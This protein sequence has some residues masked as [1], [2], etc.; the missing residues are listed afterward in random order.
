MAGANLYMRAEPSGGGRPKMIITEA[1]KQLIEN[2]AQL[3]CTDEEIAACLGTTNETLHN[4]NNKLTFLECKQKGMEK[5][6]VSLRRSQMELS[7][8][9]ATMAIFLG[10]QYL[11]QRDDPVYVVDNGS[12][13]K[14]EDPFAKALENAAKNLAQTES[15]V[16]EDLFEEGDGAD[17]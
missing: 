10:K 14:A 2:L 12:K 3:M 11:G 1:G 15:D 5:G 8:K 17:G 6:K 13:K 9:N 16:P 7:K 4:K